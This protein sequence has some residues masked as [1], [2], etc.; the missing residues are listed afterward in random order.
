M[1]QNI[2]FDKLYSEK[3]AEYLG[4]GYWINP[5]SMHGNEWGDFDFMDGGYKCK[6]HYS[7]LTRVDMTNGSEFIT[8]A[9][10]DRSYYYKYECK[11]PSE[12]T[13]NIEVLKAPKNARANDFWICKCET[14]WQFETYR[15]QGEFYGTAEQAESAADKR[16]ERWSR[17]FEADP[18]TNRKTFTSP[19]AKA[20]VLP[21][22][23][24]QRGFKTA[25]M[26]DITEVFK[27]VE[28][29]K[30]KDIVSYR[31][32]CK[33]KVLVLNASAATR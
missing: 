31:V 8:V 32:K 21:F 17:P 4:K 2:N 30:N 25:T 24:R 29:Y 9:V 7:V 10:I 6:G 3:I 23:Q 20:Y 12:Y 26:K 14:T 22:V 5:A 11:K 33:G 16:R 13:R 28:K 27:A 19:L 15:I 1:K 18:L